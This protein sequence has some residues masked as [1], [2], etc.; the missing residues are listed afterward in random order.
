[1]QSLWYDRALQE[2]EKHFVHDI[3][4]RPQHGANQEDYEEGG[5]EN[6]A[7]LDLQNLIE[8]ENW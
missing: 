3:G 8:D 5:V 2:V 6:D 1:M 7:I 4:A